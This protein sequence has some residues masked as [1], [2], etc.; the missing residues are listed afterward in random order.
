MEID[1]ATFA[2]SASAA[3][4]RQGLSFRLTPDAA[5]F[6][7]ARRKIWD[8]YVH[9]SLDPGP[10]GPPEPEGLLGLIVED[11]TGTPAATVGARR[12]NRTSVSALIGSGRLWGG[13]PQSITTREAPSALHVTARTIAFLGAM[14]VDPHWRGRRIGQVINHVIRFEVSARWKPDILFA[15][16]Q[17]DKL[18]SGLVDRYFCYSGATL[19]QYAAHGGPGEPRHAQEVIGWLTPGDAAASIRTWLDRQDGNGPAPP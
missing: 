13:A 16:L 17:P 19:C 14:A 8:G 18:G 3:L 15:L 12:F 7:E 2:E 6:A 1:H 4:R 10:A 9:P 5:A 11:Q